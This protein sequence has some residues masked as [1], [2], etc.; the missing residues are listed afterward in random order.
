MAAEYK[1]LRITE[2]S[3]V[4]DEGGIEHYFRHTIRTKGGTILTVDIDPEDFTPEK[5][6]PI[7]LAAARNADAILKL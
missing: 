6:G 3:R 4:A 5:S 7:L 2:L 1:V